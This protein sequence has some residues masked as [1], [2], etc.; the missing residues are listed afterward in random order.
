MGDN[1]DFEVAMGYFD[2]RIG[3]PFLD[4]CMDGKNVPK[5]IPVGKKLVKSKYRIINWFRKVTG[6]EKYETEYLFEW[7]IPKK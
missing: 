1:I 4:I 6:T 7:Q 3:T 2:Q 5:K